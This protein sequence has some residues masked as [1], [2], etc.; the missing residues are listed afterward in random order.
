MAIAEL[1]EALAIELL[2]EL[3]LDDEGMLLLIAELLEEMSDSMLALL[4]V[5]PDDA[6]LDVDALSEPEPPL[7]PHALNSVSN[8]GMQS[9]VNGTLLSLSAQNIRDPG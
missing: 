3:W 5:S 2:I 9:F 8:I 6:W 7:P 1:D 4:L